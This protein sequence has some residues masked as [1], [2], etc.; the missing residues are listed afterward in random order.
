MIVKLLIPESAKRS[1]GAGRKCR[2]SE[3]MV[4]DVIGAGTGTS[5]YDRSIVYRKGETVR[6]ANGWGED[7]WDECAPGIHFFLTREEAE[8][9]N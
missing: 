7:R 9:Y 8:A 4:L 5:S 6:P 1:H 2:A 3:V